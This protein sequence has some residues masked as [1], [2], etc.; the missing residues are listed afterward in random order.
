MHHFINTYKLKRTELRFNISRSLWR[1]SYFYR[2]DCW[3]QFKNEQLIGYCRYKLIF[4]FCSTWT[5]KI[6]E[7]T[8]MVYKKKHSWDNFS[9]GTN[10]TRDKMIEHR[11][12]ECRIIQWNLSLNYD[13]ISHWNWIFYRPKNIKNGRVMWVCENEFR[14]FFVSFNFEFN[15]IQRNISIVTLKLK[16][17]THYLVW[18]YLITFSFYSLVCWFVSNASWF[19]Y[20]SSFSLLLIF[21]SL[22]VLGAR[23][24]NFFFS[25]P[26]FFYSQFVC[27]EYGR[28][29]KR[30]ERRLRYFLSKHRQAIWRSRGRK[31][32]KETNDE[33]IWN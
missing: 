32:I 23:R 24:F 7:P 15:S 20:F 17:L 22:S 14:L 5:K 1:L 21:L 16:Q 31:K 26:S 4:C 10:K 25:F 27:I 29:I 13:I 11:W 28:L 33:L 6:E 8:K 19:F 9:D 12:H 30:C 3:V 2:L 18:H